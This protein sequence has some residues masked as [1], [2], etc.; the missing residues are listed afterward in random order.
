MG[1]PG[2][3]PMG[4]ERNV[5]FLA[6]YAVVIWWAAYVFRRRWPSFAIVLAGTA[7]VL[8]LIGGAPSGH[9][10]E[11]GR[12]VIE[13]SGRPTLLQIIAGAYDLLILSVGLLIAIQPRGSYANACHRCRYDLTGNLSGL[14]PECGTPVPGAMAGMDTRP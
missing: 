10:L 12:L 13:A 1:E 14:C 4:L 6:A 8:L 2:A 9:V 3:S 11:P 7:G 5:Y